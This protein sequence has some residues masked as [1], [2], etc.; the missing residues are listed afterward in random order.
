MT[1]S[2]TRSLLRRLSVSVVG[3]AVSLL[4]LST[5]AKAATFTFGSDPFAGSTAPVTPGRQVVQGEPSI[6]FNPATD[7]FAFDSSVFG[8]GNQIN[9]ANNTVDNLPTAGANVIVLQTLDNDNNPATPFG[10]GN[11]ATLI[12]NRTTSPSSGLF[13]YFNSALNVNRL[14]F[15]PDLNDPNADLAVLARTTNLSGQ[16]GIDALPTFGASN[17]ASVVTPEPSTIFLMGGALFAAVCVARRK[18]QI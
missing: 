7:V 18:K 8:L 15:S 3:A 16:A 6:S 5:T 17:F 10:A 4:A 1:F 2:A 13:I 12:A 11:A 9:F 14:V